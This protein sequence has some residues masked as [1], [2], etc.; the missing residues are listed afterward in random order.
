MA[1]H[2][3]YSMIDSFLPLDL[4]HAHTHIHCS[5]HLLINTLDQDD[6]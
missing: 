3:P 2:S 1:G 5:S 4:Q 6:K